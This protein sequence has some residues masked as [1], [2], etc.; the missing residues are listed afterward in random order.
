MKKLILSIV[1]LLVALFSVNAQG[2]IYCEILGTQGLFSKKV[3]IEVDFGQESKLFSNNSLVDENGEV[4]IFN[5]MVDAM[6]YLGT[7]GWEFEQ[8]YAITHGSGSTSTHVYHW[9]LSKYVGEEGD[10]DALKTVDIIKQEQQASKEAAITEESTATE[11]VPIAEEST[12]TEEVPI[13]E[14]TTLE[15]KAKKE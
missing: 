8:A 13:T 12:A 5:S 3:F 10:K 7:L 1:F 6:N 11:E 14:E 2:K 9:L 4:I 15:K